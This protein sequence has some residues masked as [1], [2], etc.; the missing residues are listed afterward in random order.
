LVYPGLLCARSPMG[1]VFRAQ[2]GLSNRQKECYPSLCCAAVLFPVRR[3][4]GEAASFSE[5]G[6]SFGEVDPSACEKAA[7][8]SVVGP[9]FWCP[10][11]PVLR[12]A[13]KAREHARPPLKVIYL[14]CNYRNGG[15]HAAKDI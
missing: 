11:L 2:A 6:S 1:G 9:S 3:D 7:S 4:R 5:V 12:L 14:Q 8:F 13:A 10:A 15:R